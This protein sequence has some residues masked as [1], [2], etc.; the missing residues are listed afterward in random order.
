MTV[1]IVAWERI[2]PRAEH[3]DPSTA[4]DMMTDSPSTFMSIARVWNGI[5]R[6]SRIIRAKGEDRIVV[7]PT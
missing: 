4:P 7:R 1:L 2:A 6:V 5:Q 3:S